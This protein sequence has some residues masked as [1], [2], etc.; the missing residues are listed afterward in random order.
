MKWAN[1]KLQQLTVLSKA[2]MPL[3]LRYND[4]VLNIKTAKNGVYKF[5][6]LLKKI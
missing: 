3:V 6:G 2:A 1:G 4:K 5:D